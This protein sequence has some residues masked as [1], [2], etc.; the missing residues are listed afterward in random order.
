MNQTLTS[1]AHLPVR[2]FKSLL[3]RKGAEAVV[4]DGQV[5]TGPGQQ[6]SYQQD[7]KVS[8]S[9]MSLNHRIYSLLSQP[10]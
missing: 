9:N 5:W 2:E 7:S 1:M 8:C 4:V 10:L 6:D 3:E